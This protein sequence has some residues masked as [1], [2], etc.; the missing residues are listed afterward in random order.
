MF[1][2]KKKLLA[3]SLGLCL[4]VSTLALASCNKG[5]NQSSSEPQT[6]ESAPIETIKSTNGLIYTLSADG[7]YYSVTGY[8]GTSKKVIC[9]DYYKD[10]PIKEIADNA[11]RGTA[12]EKIELSSGITKIG[13]Y[14]FFACKTLSSVTIPDTVTE[15]G[16]NAFSS[17]GITEIV[18][19]ATLK[20][21]SGTV[22]NTCKAL[23]KIYYAGSETDW[24][25][26]LSANNIQR[27]PAEVYMYSEEQPQMAGNYWHYAN[28]IPIVW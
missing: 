7:S 13:Q 20:V 5:G 16:E 11:F 26:L 6:S 24:S 12:I 4:T 25:A 21:L 19:P 10:L 3:L 18:L 9:G 22:F 15:I 2:S 17:C 1:T 14:A 27:L 8:D 28:G 23:E